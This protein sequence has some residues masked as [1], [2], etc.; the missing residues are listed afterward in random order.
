MPREEIRD[1]KVDGFMPSNCAAPPGP[2]TFPFA[3]FKALTMASRS[4]RFRSPRVSSAAFS[5]GFAAGL[6]SSRAR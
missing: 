2:N 1:A 6:V 4:W 5:A 3:C